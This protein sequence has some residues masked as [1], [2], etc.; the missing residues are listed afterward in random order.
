MVKSFGQSIAPYQALPDRPWRGRCCIGGF[1]V[2]RGL[3]RLD[4]AR[5]ANL[6]ELTGRASG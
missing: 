6:P 5:G 2:S 4:Y 3:R 1:A